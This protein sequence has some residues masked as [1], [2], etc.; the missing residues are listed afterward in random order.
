MSFVGCTNCFS[1]I[2]YICAKIDDC[3]AAKFRGHRVTDTEQNGLAIYG[4][5]GCFDGKDFYLNLNRIF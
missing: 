3:R 5:N 2:P 4:F 1:C